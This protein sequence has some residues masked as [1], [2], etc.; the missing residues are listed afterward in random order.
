M[1]VIYNKWF[2][3]EPQ[4]MV[5]VW[6]VSSE[7]RESSIQSRVR[8]A[9]WNLVERQQLCKIKHRLQNSPYFCVFKY[10][11]AV[12][13]KVWNKAENRARDWGETLHTR[14]KLARFARV[15]LLRQA[16][17]ISLL[18][19]RKKPTVLQSKVRFTLRAGMVKVG[20]Q[21][22]EDRYIRLRSHRISHHVVS[23]LRQ[24]LRTYV[25]IF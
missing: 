15:R 19:L 9:F 14:V 2:Y 5:C 25:L 22:L 11:R 10:A 23:G 17:P 16:L 12:K 13:Q 8:V 21:G 1:Y 4:P 18:I 20:T 3:Q 6:Y 7:R 24:C